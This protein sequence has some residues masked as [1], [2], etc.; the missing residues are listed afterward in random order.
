MALRQTEEKSA[1]DERDFYLLCYSSIW[2]N[3]EMR[4]GRR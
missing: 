1:E 2:V 4:I 3:T